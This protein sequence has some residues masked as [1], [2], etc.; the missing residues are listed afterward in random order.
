M[1]RITIDQQSVRVTSRENNELWASF[2]LEF[3]CDNCSSRVTTLI[4]VPI[5]NNVYVGCCVCKN[6]Q[7]LLQ[8]HFQC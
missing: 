1:V 4:E 5:R 3:L 8:I 6:P 7:D 2:W